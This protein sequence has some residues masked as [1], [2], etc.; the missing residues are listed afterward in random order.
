[1]ADTKEL[2]IKIIA[3]FSKFL[4]RQDKRILVLYGGAGSGKSH[5]IAQYLIHKFY[6]EE[7][8]RF[9]I[10]MKTLPSLRITAMQLILDLLEEYGLPYD[11]NKSQLTLN[12]K[13]NIILFKGL[14]DPGKIKSYEGNYIWMEEASENTYANFMQLNLRLRR[15][16]KKSINQMFLSL[17]PVMCWVHDKLFKTNKSNVAFLHSNYR[18]NPFLGR[19]YIEELIDLDNQDA[20]LAAI[21]KEGLWAQLR[22]LIYN[23]YDFFEELPDNI[24]DTIYGLDFGYNNPSAL[25]KIDLKDGESYETELLYKRKLTNP[26]LIKQLKIL[27]PDRSKRIYAD[28]EPDR[29]EEIKKAGFN[30]RA[31]KKGVGSVY[32]GLIFCKRLKFHV[33]MASEN[34]KKELGNYKWKEDMNGDSTEEPIK[35]FDHLMDARRMALWT[36]LGKIRRKGR[37]TI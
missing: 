25:V 13:D 6:T 20:T 37:V 30:C 26:D 5:S 3:K 14:D 9:L 24:D 32:N 17:N 29:I 28:N 22:N 8:K 12:Y 21:Y 18:D 27:I 10:T 2:R 34:S 4:Q 15:N 16:S 19:E 1:M 23:N 7:N 33:N 31:A 36:H 11:F 35:T